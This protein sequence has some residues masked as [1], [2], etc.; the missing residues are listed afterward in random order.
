M[1]VV[2]L[3]LVGMVPDGITFKC[4]TCFFPFFPF[5]S[6]VPIYSVIGYN[7]KN[8]IFKLNEGNKHLLV[9]SGGGGGGAN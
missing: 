8:E 2:G 9:L 3:H 4:H 7:Y 6:A 1:E 5:F